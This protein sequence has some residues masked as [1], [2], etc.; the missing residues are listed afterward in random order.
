MNLVAFV[1]LQYHIGQCVFIAPDSRQI[2]DYFVLLSF[3]ML[4]LD[5]VTLTCIPS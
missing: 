4:S 1:T 3:R 2:P 5:C